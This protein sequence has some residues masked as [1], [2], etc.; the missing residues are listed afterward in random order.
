MSR[1]RGRSRVA[2]VFAVVAIVAVA[3]AAVPA[4]ADPIADIASVP[5]KVLKQIKK[6]LSNSK[7][8]KATAEEALTVA[9]SIPA[10]PPGPAGKDGAQ[11]PVGPAGPIG[12]TGKT[13]PAGADG[14]PGAD[15]QPWTPENELPSGA[16][17]TGGFSSGAY[18]AAVPP[19]FISLSFPVRL[20]AGGSLG[21]VHAVHTGQTPPAE[22]VDDN[23][24]PDDTGDDI[25][26]TA[27]D[28]IADPGHLCVYVA[29]QSDAAAGSGDPTIG[30]IFQLDAAGLSGGYSPA[31]AMLLVGDLDNSSPPFGDTIWGTFA[32][33]AP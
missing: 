21:D 29:S 18:S 11:G 30:A 7:S 12:P 1:F 8:A 26:G 13:G 33:T 16:T 32:V 4:A 24:T 27:T 10:G 28:P 19:Q 22:C 31:G 17:L 14:A 5:K 9:K 2:G 15:G 20:A 25:E 6:A 23:G 3:A